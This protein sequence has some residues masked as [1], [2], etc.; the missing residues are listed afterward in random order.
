MKVGWWPKCLIWRREGDSNPRYIFTMYNGLAN[1]R[2]QPLGHPSVP[3]SHDLVSRAAGDRRRSALGANF[4]VRRLG[5]G[6][7]AVN[8]L[9]S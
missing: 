8:A 9:P 2:L 1:R 4:R 3:A 5:I 7:G 6:T